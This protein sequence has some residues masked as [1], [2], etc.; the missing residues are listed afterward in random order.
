MKI[1]VFG[2][3]GFIGSALV[4]QLSLDPQNE[5]F[6]FDNLSMGN[7]LEATEFKGRIH[8]GDCRNFDEV[9]TFMR[10]ARP[11]RIFHLVANSD[12]RRSSLNPKIEYENT[13]V[14]T[15]NIVN[16]IIPNSEP[17]VVFASSSAIYG[18]TKE[19]ISENELKNPISPYGWMKLSSEA[20][21]T[22]SLA[23]GTI[24]KLVGFRFPNVV[25]K[26]MT[27][28]VIFDFFRKLEQNPSIL[29]ILGDGHQRKP[30]ID[31]EQLVE[32]IVRIT[33]LETF[34]ELFVNVSPDDSISV[35]KIVQILRKET[36][37]DFEGKYQESPIG[38]FGDVPKYSF[39]TSLL[40]TLLPEFQI[41]SSEEAVV[42]AIR[43]QILESSL[44]IRRF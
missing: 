42:R 32:V 33:S 23:A 22:S 39:S 11:E 38:W 19:P 25:G 3:A 7:K 43:S 28:G 5:I 37:L 17:Q 8:V 34:K 13:F 41:A 21:L 40:H 4:H 14:S 10:V 24:S 35:R 27:H 26:R 36:G 18:L 31:V 30:Y 6:V 9:V 20:L 1:A 44:R 16:A 29:Q 2:G 15:C 12:I